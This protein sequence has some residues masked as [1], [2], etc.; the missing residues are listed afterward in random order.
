MP[1]RTVR[2]ALPVVGLTLA[3]IKKK[4]LPDH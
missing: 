3:S 1:A 2:I 4:E